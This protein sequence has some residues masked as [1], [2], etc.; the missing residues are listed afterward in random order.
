MASTVSKYLSKHRA[1]KPIGKFAERKDMDRPTHQI[2]AG[3]HPPK[4][5][6]LGCRRGGGEPK[7]LNNLDHSKG[8][9][10]QVRVIA[11]R[12]A[13]PRRDAG[14]GNLKRGTR[15]PEKLVGG[16]SGGDRLRSR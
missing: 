12:R 15:G 1:K 9:I 7:G 16:G 10:G 6:K 8:R 13:V 3:E 2:N 11:E 5:D 4:P 14:G